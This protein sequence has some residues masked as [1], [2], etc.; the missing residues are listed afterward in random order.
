MACGFCNDACCDH[1]VD[2][3]LG[4]A[5]RLRGAAA[6]FSRP[7]RRARQRMVHRRCDPGSEFPGGAHVRTAVRDGACVF[8][9][10]P[11]AAAPSMPIAWNTGST[12]IAQA[13][14]ERAV[15]RDLR[16]G[17]A[18]RVGRG[19]GRKPDLRGPAAPAFMTARGRAPLL[20]RGRPDGRAG[21]SSHSECSAMVEVPSFRRC[22]GRRRAHR[23]LC[24]AHAAGGK[25]GC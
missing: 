4:N 1:G 18:D 15:S 14:G 9:N 11:G 13:D 8:R 2:V 6:G 17:R 10:P 23:A 19:G 16:A 3:D 21:G 24:G 25:P 5:A 12:T 20:F 7:D 22:S